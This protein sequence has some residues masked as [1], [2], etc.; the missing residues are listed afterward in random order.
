MISVVNRP[1]HRAGLL[2]LSTP[3]WAFL[4]LMMAAVAKFESMMNARM[5]EESVGLS[6]SRLRDFQEADVESEP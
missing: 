4:A 5:R 6:R 2:N 3:L 1:S